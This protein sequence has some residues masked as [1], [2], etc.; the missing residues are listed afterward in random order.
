MAGLGTVPRWVS[1]SSPLTFAVERA[2]AFGRVRHD[3]L[4]LPEDLAGR[5]LATSLQDYLTTRRKMVRTILRSLVKWSKAENMAVTSPRLRIYDTILKGH[6]ERNRQMAFV[7]GPRQVGK[8]TTCRLEGTDYLNWDNADD[9]R[10]ILRGPA[11]VAE[12]LALEQL[13]SQRTIA[14]MDEL[15]K[16]AKWKSFLKGFF[17]VYGERTRLIAYLHARC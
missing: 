1:L 14:V 15:H 3:F 17:D 10:V 6:L 13:R 5:R 11:A 7:S 16:Y 2:E 8:T 9:R 4:S 12:R